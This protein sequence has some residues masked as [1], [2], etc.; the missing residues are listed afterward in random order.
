MAYGFYSVLTF[1]SDWKGNMKKRIPG[2]AAL[3]I[4]VA[5]YF[6]LRSFWFDLHGMKEWPLYLFMVGGIII[7]LSGLG[8]RNRLLPLCTAFGYLAGFWFG[9]SLQYDSSAGYN[10]LWIPW[11]CFYTAAICTGII[12][13]VIVKVQKQKS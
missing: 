12:L 1:A 9:Y 7:A 11:T 8:F 2:L 13:T 3:L 4:V 5:V 6:C 10:T